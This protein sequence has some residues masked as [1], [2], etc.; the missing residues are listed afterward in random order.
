M[1]LLK[2]TKK[3]AITQDELAQKIA[4]NIISRQQ[5]IADFLNEKT[6]NFSPKFWLFA[7]I[8]FCTTLGSYCLYLLISAFN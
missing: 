4:G 7:L 3:E 6:K 8:A 5:R 1:N 2:G